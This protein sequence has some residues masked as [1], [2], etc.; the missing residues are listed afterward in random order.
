MVVLV[1]EEVNS[2]A[3]FVTFR[4]QV[5]KLFYGSFFCI[6]FFLNTLRKIVGI[7]IAKI[8]EH[9][10]AMRIQPFAVVVQFTDNSG[11]I[12]IE[13]QVAVAVTCGIF[14][15]IKIT[16]QS[17]KLIFGGYVVIMLQHTYRQTFAETTGADEEEK[18]IR[19]FYYG[20][21]AGL[22][23]IIT[24]I[25]ANHGEVHH[26]VGDAFSVRCYI[27]FHN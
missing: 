18:L 4:K 27:F 24:I 23:Y 1:D 2:L 26:A 21:K 3:G 10:L 16:E 19:V 25:T 11:K 12:E 17:I 20:N 9:G 13:H 5:L 15:D 14:P 7:D 6:Q 22:V 8:V